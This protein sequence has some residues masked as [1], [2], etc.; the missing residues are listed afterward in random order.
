[1]LIQEETRLKSLYEAKKFIYVNDSLL[2]SNDLNLLYETKN[3]FSNNFEMKNM[4]E[5]TY[6]IGIE[7]FWDRSQKLFG[8]S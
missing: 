1:M 4:R 7:I 5:V 3:I 8:L 2:E 6:V